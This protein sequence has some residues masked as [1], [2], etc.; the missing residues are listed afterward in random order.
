MN[1]KIFFSVLLT[2][3]L[4][5]ACAERADNIKSAAPSPS[6]PVASTSEPAMPSSVDATVKT[7]FTTLV[8]APSQEEKLGKV[9]YSLEI[10]NSLTVADSEQETEPPSLMKGDEWY[11]MASNVTCGVGADLIKQRADEL[12]S[13]TESIS[14]L[15][16]P[17]LLV[18]APSEKYSS[19][20][21]TK[22]LMDGYTYSYFIMLEEEK[23]ISFTFFAEKGDD[24][25]AK[26][27]F[28]PIV[29]S[30]ALS[31]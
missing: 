19:A 10:P 25:L 23:F 5:T 3:L 21:E 16:Y 14:T 22:K 2:T 20:D 18:M 1:T 13:T 15:A 24:E 26:A 17:V 31:E 6:S 12:G 4:L 11:M 28:R 29:A 27:E 9:V 8:I 30:F 7:A